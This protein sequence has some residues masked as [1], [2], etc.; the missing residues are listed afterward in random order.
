MFVLALIQFR[1]AEGSAARKRP[2]TGT[3]TA[4]TPGLGIRQWPARHQ[5]R[6]RHTTFAW[7][8]CCRTLTVSSTCTSTS[9]QF[10]V[11]AVSVVPSARLAL[12][13]FFSLSL[14]EV[15]NLE[16]SFQNFLPFFISPSALLCS[17]LSPF[18]IRHCVFQD[19]TRKHFLGLR[20]ILPSIIGITIQAT[21]RAPLL[22]RR[23]LRECGTAGLCSRPG[24]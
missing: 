1:A 14:Q 17:T 23:E 10:L 3:C 9:W 13:S 16:E 24:C 4:C 22:G 8:H 7:P 19:G 6:I 12:H 5:L 18:F 15:S 21:F 20:H 2:S 11:R